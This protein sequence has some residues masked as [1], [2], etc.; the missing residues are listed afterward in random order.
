M[1][2]IILFQVRFG[3]RT[4]P[5][6]EPNLFEPEPMVQFGVRANTPNRTNGLVRG[7]GKRP[8]EPNRT[9]LYHHYV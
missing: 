1:N 7:S 9:E 4:L 2:L 6:P 3:V 5:E 8:P